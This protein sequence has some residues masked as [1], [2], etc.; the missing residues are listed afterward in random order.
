MRTPTYLCILLLSVAAVILAPAYA[1]TSATSS[2]TVDALSIYSLQVSPNPIFAGSNVSINLQLYDSYTSQLQNVNLE[3][4]GSYPIL[5]VSPSNP[6]L[7][8][9]I[10]QGLY[11]G[12]NSYFAYSIKIPENTPS[13]NYTLDLVAQYQTVQTTAGVST[14]VTGTSVMPI[15]FYVHGTPSISINPTVTRIS[16]GNV[17]AV[18][19]SVMNSGY[20]TARNITVS[21]LNS[22]NF[23]ASG[24]RRFSI[25]S[26]AAGASASL[27]ATYLVNSHITNG[28]YEIPVYVAYQSD[29]GSWYNQTINQSI[30]VRIQNPNIVASIV[31]ANPSTLYSGYNQS[32]VISIQNRGYGNANNVSVTLAPK[33][34]VSVLSSVRS[35]FIGSLPAGQSATETVLVTANNYTGG[36]ASLNAAISYYTSNYQREFSKN[37]SL[38]LS[39]AQSAIFQIGNGRYRLLAG[40]TTV[41]VNFTITNTGDVDAQQLQ[42]SFQSSYPLTPVSGSG[43]IQNLEPGQSENVSFLVSIDSHG[44][45]G[46]YPITIYETWRQPDGAA[47][48]SYTGSSSYYATVSSASSGGLGSGT[49]AIIAVVVIVIIAVVVYRRMSKRNASKKKTPKAL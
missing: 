2:S 45:P 43:Y 20:G 13:G 44:A 22:S 10:G 30:A 7:I 4:E 9:S 39:V 14:Q 46:T 33:Q 24:T 38:N 1:A 37:Q 41:P 8:S 31:S 17:S 28:T 5:N 27:T 40:A 19:L 29:Q 32:L 47:Q 36:A 48:Q 6:Y 49:T 11:G 34:G 21:I 15:T 26:L 18:T 16:P 23:S 12:I 25:G 3:L 42:L 35:F